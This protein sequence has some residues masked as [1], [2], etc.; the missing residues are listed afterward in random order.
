MRSP[1]RHVPTTPV[2][3]E[4]PPNPSAN[5]CSSRHAGPGKGCRALSRSGTRNTV[6]IMESFSPRLGFAPAGEAGFE[7]ADELGGEDAEEDDDD[8]GH[9][10]VGGAQ[11][12]AV[13]GH[14][15]A[16]AGVGAEHLAEHD[17]DEGAADADAQAGQ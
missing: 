3:R 13:G 7:E 4:K 11:A 14:A 1:A 12:G 9:E 5:R 6:L 2:R 8:H 10:D 16:E 15:E 17:A